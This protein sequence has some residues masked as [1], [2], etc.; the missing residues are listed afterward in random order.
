MI[1]VGVIQPAN[2]HELRAIIYRSSFLLLIK[3]GR[4][5]AAPQAFQVAKIS[6]ETFSVREKLASLLKKFVTDRSQNF[7]KATSN[8]V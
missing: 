8:T 5:K 4:L 2:G 6:I 1:F 7:F 3:R